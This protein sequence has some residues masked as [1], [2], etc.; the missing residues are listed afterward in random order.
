[1]KF[2]NLSWSLVNC[3]NDIIKNNINTTQLTTSVAFNIFATAIV[4]N[5]F[6][7]HNRREMR[8]VNTY[9][10]EINMNNEEKRGNM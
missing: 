6:L 3:V 10:I 7:L 8:N 9:G 5:L 1:M 2:S 4:L